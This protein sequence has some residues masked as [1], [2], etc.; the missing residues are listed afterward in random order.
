MS[1]KIENISKEFILENSDNFKHKSNEFGFCWLDSS[2]AIADKGQNSLL[3]TE[4]IAEIYLLQNSIH[5]QK[6]ID[7]PIEFLN[8]SN[9]YN[10][11]EEI[12]KRYDLYAVGYISY[13]SSL[14]QFGINQTTQTELPEV[15][16]LFY[17]D[18]LEFNSNDLPQFDTIHNQ[19][20]N[21]SRLLTK[22]S[23]SEYIQ[24][25]KKIK[26]HIKEG[27]IYQANYTT[28][29]QLTSPHDTIDAY[30]NLR[31]LNPAPYASYLNFGNYQLL[32]S[33]PERMF[34]LKENQ[35]STCPIKGT[36]AIGSNNAERE[37]NLSALLNSAKD[38]AELLMIVDLMRN[39]LG[40]IA[41]TGTVNIG[42]LF[43]PEIYSSLIHLVSDI[44]AEINSNC[45]LHEIISA[46]IPG[47]SI[48]GAPKK[49]A[50]EII[51]SVEQFPRFVYTGS[52]GY[53]SK[54]KIDFNIAIRTMYQYNNHYFIH[55]GG[56]IVADSNPDDEYDEMLLKAKNLFRA[57][58]YQSE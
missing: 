41:N 30:F 40:K 15:R 29:F 43:K 38:K 7:F 37:T 10:C 50:I 20:S 52:I 49:R 34:T 36:I 57:I 16:F 9:I 46:L 14:K 8:D 44:S 11:I 25:V 21:N 33:S 55:A 5:F 2:M 42:S 19:T 1:S 24:N 32:S 4:P 31:E 17:K 48:T 45:S 6:Y 51:D 18:K 58:G 54:E 27:D 13:E 3:F 26:E 47:G 12:V 56:G 28:R 39:D 53:I 35:I 23:K 22:I